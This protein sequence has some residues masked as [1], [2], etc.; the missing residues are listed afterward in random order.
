MKIG[1]M[2]SEICESVCKR[3]LADI[4]SDELVEVIKRVIAP[5]Q[6]LNV[7]YLE[8]CVSNSKSASN[9]LKALNEID[10][11]AQVQIH[12]IEDSVKFAYENSEVREGALEDF[13]RS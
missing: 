2:A 5:L 13:K 10:L 7:K 6:N 12:D 1:V 11:K 9:L 8:F 3:P 4:K